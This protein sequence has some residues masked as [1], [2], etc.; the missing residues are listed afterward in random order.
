[1][2]SLQQTPQG[3]RVHI[4]LFGRRNVGKSSLINALTGQT[5]SIVSEVKGTTTDPVS[6]AMELLPLGPV[7][8]IDTPGLDDEGDLGS[9]RVQRTLDIL[10]KT[11]LAILVTTA[12]AGIGSCER[13]LVERLREK[14]LPFVTVLN[15]IDRLVP[16]PEAIRAITGETGSPVL[17][18]SSV[19]R[20]GIDG[21]KS[22]LIKAVPDADGDRRII[23]DLLQPGDLVVLVTPIDSAAPKGRL[24]HPQQQV[25]RDILDTGAAAVVTQVPQLAG[26]LGGLT[27]PPRLVVTDS[28]AFGPVSAIVPQ[29]VPLTSFSILF[30]R[31]KGD[32]ATLKAGA[33]AVAALKDGDRI[34]IAEGCTHHRQTDDIGTVKI[35]R[36]LEK[37][38]G[39]RLVFD[40][41]SG[42]QYARNLVWE[43]TT[44]VHAAQARSSRTVTVRIFNCFEYAFVYNLDG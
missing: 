1:M 2:S 44:H 14:K 40:Q 33:D 5:V 29:T 17:A 11:D 4:A 6:K 41:T 20:E 32:L 8:F 21:L 28:Q 22:A 9:L 30:A 36:M 24:I 23:G 38:T 15:Q 27:A 35:P 39:K 25:L 42:I 3:E 12:E 31:Y 10:N 34:L 37:K 13:Q 16:D 19:T 18:V 7:V 26:V 43:G